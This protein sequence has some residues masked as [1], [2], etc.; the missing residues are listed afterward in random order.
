LLFGLMLKSVQADVVPG[1]II[2]ASNYQQ[3]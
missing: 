3:I 1:D 2:N